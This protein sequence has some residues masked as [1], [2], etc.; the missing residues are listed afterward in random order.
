MPGPTT[1]FLNEDLRELRGSYER[2][3]VRIAEASL[4]LAVAK[5]LLGLT[6]LGVLGV[7]CAG[8]WRAG[9]M[10]SD[11]R[12][13]QEGLSEVKAELKEVKAGLKSV[14]ARLDRIDSRFDRLEEIIT[15]ALATKAAN[16]P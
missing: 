10:S 8:L 15:K 2:P 12:H 14:D 11:V 5:C 13:L 6:V 16:K 3:T 4:K 7:V 9:S 1:E